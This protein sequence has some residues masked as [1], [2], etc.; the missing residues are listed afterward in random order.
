VEA[1]AP[2]IE[3]IE[4]LVAKTAAL[5]S[6]KAPLVVVDDNVVILAA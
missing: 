2:P 4:E 1:G 3:E 6:E 5:C